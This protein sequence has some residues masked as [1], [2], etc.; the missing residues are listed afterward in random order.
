[1]YILITDDNI[2]ESNETFYLTIEEFS[3][4]SKVTTDGAISQVNVTITNND[5]KPAASMCLFSLK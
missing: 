1:M 4:P 2:L 3:L 5:G